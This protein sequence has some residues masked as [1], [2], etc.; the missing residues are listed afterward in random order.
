[1]VPVDLYPAPPRRDARRR[2]G[3]SCR[4]PG[5]RLRA[6]FVGLK[7]GEVAMAKSLYVGNLPYGASEDEVRNLFSPHGTVQ[8]VR[9]V[10]DRDTGRSRGFAFVDMEP[11]EADTAVSVL[12]G[13]DFGGR[14][15]RV[16]EAH[17]RGAA[18][19]MPATVGSRW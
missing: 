2:N 6:G 15:L 18:R 1:M 9:L 17:D 16:N 4:S 14:P 5:L 13:S 8:E 7:Q 10:T 12:N 11:R 3:G 19:R